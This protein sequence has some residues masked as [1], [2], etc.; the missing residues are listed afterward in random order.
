M[1][2]ESHEQG[3]KDMSPRSM[4]ILSSVWLSQKKLRHGA[5]PVLQWCAA[6]A[7]VTRDRAGGR[8]FDKDKKLWANRRARRACEGGGPHRMMIRA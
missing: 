8:K 2:L 4:S 7:V 6:N 1:P 3:Y 5:H